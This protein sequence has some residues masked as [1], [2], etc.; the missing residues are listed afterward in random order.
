MLSAAG[1]NLITPHAVHTIIGTLGGEVNFSSI[2]TG[3]E[4]MK[5]GKSTV[6][7]IKIAAEQV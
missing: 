7:A 3:V 4:A 6:E 2:W 5:S 1:I